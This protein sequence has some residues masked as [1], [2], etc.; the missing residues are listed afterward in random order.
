MGGGGEREGEICR[1]GERGGGMKRGGEREYK[2]V[3]TTSQL[4]HFNARWKFKCSIRAVANGDIFLNERPV[5]LFSTLVN[6]VKLLLEGHD[7]R[8]ES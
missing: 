5:S 6:H 7:F 3:S 1:E 4:A 2:S 8:S